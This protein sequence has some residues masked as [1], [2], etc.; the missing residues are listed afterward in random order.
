MVKKVNSIRRLQKLRHLVAYHREKYHR[1]DAPEISD[2]A[3]DALL[4]ELRTLEESQNEKVTADT[5]G[6]EVSQAFAKVTHRVRQWSFDNVFDWSELENWDERL[7]RLLRDADSRAD[8][9]FV[10]E[11]KLDGLK[12]IVTY[13]K[14]RLVQAVTRGNGLVGEDVTHTART[15]TT[16]PLVLPKPVSLVCVG[17]VIFTKENFLRLNEV[18]QEKGEPLFANARNAAAGTLRQLNPTIAKER[19]L[20]FFA[21]DI[22]Y[23]DTHQTKLKTPVT[24]WEELQ[25]LRELSLPVNKEAR[26]CRNLVEVEQCYQKWVKQRRDYPYEIDGAVIKVN[27]IPVQ[28]LLGYTAKGPR[29]G[30]AYKMPTEQTTTVVEAIELQVGRT[31]VVTPVAHLRPVKVAGST[32]ARATLHNEDQIKRLDVRVGDTVILQKAGDVIPEVVAVLTDLRPPRTKPYK[33][34]THVAGCGGDGR[35]ERIPGEVAYRCVVTDSSFLRQQYLYYVVGKTALNIDGVGPKII[36]KLLE[37]ELIA[38]PGDLFTLSHSDVL[39]LPGFKDQSAQ[40]VIEAIYKAKEQPLYRVIVA[41]GIET[42]GEETARLLVQYFN[43]IEELQKTSVE[44]LSAIHGI[45]D[46]TA[47]AIVSWFKNPQHQALL[48]TLLQHLI[49]TNDEKS[50]NAT[51]AGQTVVVTGT[52]ANYSR[53]E[54]KDL[55]RRLGGTVT[56]SVSKKTSFVLV[57][58]EPGNKAMDAERLGVECLSETEFLVRCGITASEVV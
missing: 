50:V 2:E 18:M 7:K 58:N 42:V 54:I 44:K 16:L 4:Q 38:T 13:E 29:F 17:E 51:L 39:N 30:I 11:H 40:N 22:D 19:N 20:S 26:L 55:I 12:L 24:Q 41:L 52:L 48:G 37:A 49:V 6:G 15:I 33:F 9:F 3:Y 35:I 23:I 10:V 56:S 47:E 5:V 53:D 45:G 57:G 43:T 28:E 32:V 27:E 1:D 36:D 31:G 34:P 46:A 14:G 8:Y 25:L 21:Y